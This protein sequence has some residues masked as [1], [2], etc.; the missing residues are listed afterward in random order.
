MK[1]DYLAKINWL[2]DNFTIKDENMN[3][4]IVIPNKKFT[5]FFDRVIRYPHCWQWG[6]EVIN[7]NCKTRI[8]WVMDGSIDLAATDGFAL[9]EAK[10]IVAAATNTNYPVE[11]TAAHRTSGVDCD[12]SGFTFNGIHTVDGEDRTISYYDEIWIFAIE[13]S[14]DALDEAIE[15]PVLTEFMNNG[16][17]VFAT[18]DHASLGAALCENIPRV[19]SMRRWRDGTPPQTGTTRH[20]TNVPNPDFGPRFDLQA[21]NIAQRIY[22]VW[23]T[24]QSVDYQPHP[25]LEMPGGNVATHLPDHPHEGICVLPDSLDSE[26]YPMGV[27]P[28]MA[29]YG[30]S[31]GPGFSGTKPSIPEPKLFGVIGAYDGHQASIGRVVVDSTWHHWLNVNLNGVGD[32]SDGIDQKGLYDAD[33][34]PTPEYLEIQQY[35]QNI[36]SWLEPN[37]FRICFIIRFICIRWSW[38]FIEELIEFEKPDFEKLID[39]GQS[40]EKAIIKFQGNS[41]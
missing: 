3:Q 10:E 21:D 33:G 36:A 17:G 29:A 26:E 11:I 28:E 1:T 9:S 24:S 27:A 16:G 19:K 12:V 14:T 4:N 7:L 38:P 8:L 13:S 15:L 22:P 25:L 41:G 40:V 32:S 2:H 39:I 35:F 34:N 6:T 37:R 18:G 23:Q 30:V 5:P 31:A 20:D